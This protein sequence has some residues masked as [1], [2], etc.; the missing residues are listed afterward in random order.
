M[1][2]RAILPFSLI[3]IAACASAAQGKRHAVA[4]SE[5]KWTSLPPGP[6]VIGF[7]STLLRAQA[8]EFHHGPQHLVQISV[9]YPAQIGSGTAMTLRDYA[10]IKTNENTYDEPSESAKQ[11]ALAEVPKDLLDTPMIARLNAVTP[12][13]AVRVPIVFIAPG[14]GESAVDHAMLA[15]F[16]ASH[17]Y[18]VVTVPSVTRLTTNDEALRAQEQADDIDRAASAIGDWPNAVNIPVSVIGFDL[19]ADAAAIYANQ[20]PVNAVIRGNGERAQAIL[21]R[22]D[23]I[24]DPIRPR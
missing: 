9:W 14:R 5:S 21:A 17:G 16:I 11:A 22:L 18:I 1:F 4:P 2:R 3:L 6:V 13:N 24:W 12:A 8:S 23:Q 15:E 10:L 19:G 7:K 20:H